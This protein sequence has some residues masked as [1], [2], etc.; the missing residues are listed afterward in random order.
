L[1]GEITV[2]IKEQ[3]Q[4]SGAVWI[5]LDGLDAGRDAK[6]VPLEIDDPVAT[7]V[8]TPT[9]TNGDLASKI[10]PGAFAQRAEQGALRLGSSDLLKV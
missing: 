7:L 5:V 2:G 9:T 8:A 4:T 1:R 3:S 10:A 6:F